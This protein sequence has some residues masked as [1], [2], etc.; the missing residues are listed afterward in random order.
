MSV[1]KMLGAALLGMFLVSQCAW[2]QILS[3]QKLS[4]EFIPNDACAAAT[5]FPKELAENPK[6]EM[7]PRE[8]I[9]A[10]GQQEFGFD[11]MLIEEATFV[12]DTP[13]T[14]D[15]G[16]PMWAAI[17]RFHE[18]QG[19]SDHVTQRLDETTLGG[20]TV[21]SS[22]GDGPS[23]LVYDDATMF[24]GDEGL[25]KSMLNADRSGDLAKLVKSTKLK[26]QAFAFG[27]VSQVRDLINE[28]LTQFDG[29]MMPP[30]LE[31]L[32]DI[33]NLVN[34]L[35][36]SVS[37]DDEMETTLAL[38]TESN[39][40][41]EEVKKILVDGIAMGKQMLIA[42]MAGSMSS[43]D[44]M[45]AASIQ[46]V[47]RLVESYEQKL[48]PAVNGSQLIMKLESESAMAPVFVGMLLP[49]LQSVRSAAR[50]T[51]SANRVR[52][53]MLSMHN[54][55][56][57]HG[58]LPAKASYDDNGKPLLS[59]RVHMLPYLGEDEL[60]RKF[61]LDEPW[62]SDHNSRLINEMPDHF[63]C[64]DV[65]YLEGKTV[66]LGVTGEGMAL[67]DKERSFSEITDG[68]S[69]TVMLVEADASRAQIWTKPADYEFDEDRPMHGLGG[70]RPD[71]F[72]AAFM[73]GSVQFMSNG[74][75]E[76]VWKSLLTIA[77]GEVVDW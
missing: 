8:I 67:G 60:Y 34:S 77:G 30:P 15:E 22:D 21:Y 25:F 48:T 3:K 4:N 10:W 2:A 65:G 72:N 26:G 36:L 45:S 61:N 64:P 53:L 6:L 68:T 19:L 32:L 1:R 76:E 33:P 59:W 20:K 44:P 11:P 46:Y 63:V 17:L 70:N 14:L 52:Q 47:R 24:V 13:E 7:V 71:G 12:V 23:F 29:M 55:A 43:D 50:R 31:R 75:D 57:A 35:E 66:Y 49:A 40:K 74:L 37:S 69:N 18:M 56:S 62:D 16:P 41:A 9:T 51:D 27:D 39:E 5:L 42:Q 73:D 38:N 58:K 28:Q 54:Y